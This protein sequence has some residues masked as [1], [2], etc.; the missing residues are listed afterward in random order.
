MHPSTCA[1]V[2]VDLDSR[3]LGCS[4]RRRPLHLPRD[5]ATLCRKFRLP[6]WRL[7]VCTFYD[8][9]GQMHQSSLEKHL[10]HLFYR[11]KYFTPY[12]EGDDDVLTEVTQWQLFFA[13][14]AALMIR[15][16]QTPDRRREEQIFSA[17]L[18]VSS[19]AAF[20]FVGLNYLL[21]FMNLRKR[22]ATY[23]MERAATTENKSPG[24]AAKDKEEEEDAGREE[25][26]EEGRYAGG[27]E[28]VINTDEERG[29][30]GDGEDSE[31]QEGGFVGQPFG[32]PMVYGNDA[33]TSVL[34]GAEPDI[35]A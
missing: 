35:E 1:F 19:C 10:L 2:D 32:A 15:V 30:A 31:T 20:V 34:N 14:F 26:E 28:D 13:F 5:D 4:N 7:V 8:A 23:A 24:L 17:L 9:L 29:D 21:V 12:A 22:V 11:I 16:D 3:R 25:G 6:H 18:I 33:E 27:R